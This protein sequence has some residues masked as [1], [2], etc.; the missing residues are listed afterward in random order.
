MTK[1]ITPDINDELGEILS[2][3]SSKELI[4]RHSGVNGSNFYR[5]LKNLQ[6]DATQ[7]IE[8]Y[9]AQREIGQLKWVKGQGSKTNHCDSFELQIQEADVDF[10]IAQLKAQ[11]TNNMGGEDG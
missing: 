4:L 2:Q 9:V 6:L 1:P 7:A 5:K 3:L 8:A 11:L 10:R